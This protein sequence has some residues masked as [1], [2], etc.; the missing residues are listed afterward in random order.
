IRNGGIIIELDST[1]TV[2]WLRGSE[3]RNS[4]IQS[5]QA[6]VTFK[7]R[8]YH[9]LVPF[10]PLTTNPE[11]TDTLRAI[12]EENGMNPN[13]IVN[14]RWIKPPNRRNPQQTCAHAMMVLSDP[15]AANS[16]LRD[17]LLVNSLKLHP[18]KDKKE[19]IRCA[20][21]HLWGHMAR[22]CSAPGDTCGTCGM[23]HKTTDCPETNKKHCVSCNSSSH[24]SWSRECPEF[25]RRCRDID[26]KHAENN[27]PY[28][29]TLEP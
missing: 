14:M 2:E 21:C 12:E 9:I 23:E 27:M 29:P 10:L 22:D 15:S 13:V 11:H 1:E 17:G 28:F 19:P 18:R 8:F 5:L 26:L 20:K 16:L 24:P 7:E 25:K 3:V 4:F 6:A